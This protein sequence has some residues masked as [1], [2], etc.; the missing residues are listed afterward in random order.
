MS[1]GAPE[2]STTRPPSEGGWSRFGAELPTGGSGTDG[3]DPVGTASAPLGAGGSSRWDPIPPF[4]PSGDRDAYDEVIWGADLGLAATTSGPA[5]GP[6]VTGHGL[7]PTGSVPATPPRGRLPETPVEYPQLLRGPTRARWRPLA[8]LLVFLALFAV[9]S[10]T[11]F[12][13]AMAYAAV[14]GV[15]DIELWMD[16]QLAEGAVT[17]PGGYLFLMFSLI[18]LIPAAMLSIWAV[19]RI[20]PRFLSSVAGGLRWRW[21]LRCVVVLAPLWVVYLTVSTIVDPPQSPRST[22]WLALLI[23]GLLLTPWQAA[24]EEYAFRGW[25]AQNIGAYFARPLVA[26]LVPTVIA[27][28]AFAAA[29]GSPDP[30]ILADLALF[31]VVASVMTWRTGGLEAA[32][33]MHAVN[34]V[35][36]DIVVSAVGGFDESLVGA[37]TTSSPLSFAISAALSLIAL[38]LVLWQARRRGLDRFYRPTAPRESGLRTS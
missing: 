30:W 14:T 24:A 18:I 17:E 11:P 3:P 5:D 6:V 10:V 36:I 12:L 9:L 38:G 2:P 20:R 13:V 4:R 26:F 23:I 32:I 27:A 31:S 25:L 37:E 15:G 7:T 16:E 35:G 33:V 21:L 28:A 34:N 29:H 8:T 19:H 22:D 1:T